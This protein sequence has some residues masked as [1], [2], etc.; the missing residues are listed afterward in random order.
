MEDGALSSDSKR[1]LLHKVP[2]KF[3]SE[4]KPFLD[5]GFPSILLHG[6][7]H[8]HLVRKGARHH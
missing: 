1:V 8:M 3:F 4:K 6:E 7:L 5:L 2:S